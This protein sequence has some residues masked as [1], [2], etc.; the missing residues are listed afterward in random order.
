MNLE[1]YGKFQNQFKKVKQERYL[2]Q[3]GYQICIKMFFLSQPLQDMINSILKSGKMSETWKEVN[4]MLIPKEGQDLTIAR[5]YTQ[6]LL[7]NNDY[8]LFT[9][10][11]AE[12]LKIIFQDFIHEN[13]RG[14]SFQINMALII[15]L[16][17]SMILLCNKFMCYKC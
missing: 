8:K 15:F 11:L 7:L 14:F 1:R 13:Q 4:I 2:G 12:R 5:N 3:M 16:K 9:M 17:N 10:I 6:I